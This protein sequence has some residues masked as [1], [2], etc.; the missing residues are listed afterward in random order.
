MQHLCCWTSALRRRLLPPVTFRMETKLYYI[1]IRSEKI[2]LH[3]PDPR[4]PACVLR[5]N[6]ITG[7]GQAGHA[8]HA[9]AGV[10]TLRPTTAVLPRWNK[11]MRGNNAYCVYLYVDEK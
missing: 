10:F 4:W 7:S 11:A 1:N 5:C 9:D 2:L 6:W 3:S 8:K